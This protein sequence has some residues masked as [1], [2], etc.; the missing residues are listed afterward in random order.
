MAAGTTEVLQ[1][2]SIAHALRIGQDQNESVRLLDHYAATTIA[3]YACIRMCD[4]NGNPSE[5]Y[6][7]LFLL[8]PRK[9]CGL[10]MNVT[11]VE[12]V[13][14]DLMNKMI[15][16]HEEA[17]LQI[18]DDVAVCKWLMKF[19]E[20]W[21]EAYRDQTKQAYD[22]AEPVLAVMH[23]AVL[24]T[25]RVFETHAPAIAT[26]E[27][28]VCFERW[29]DENSEEME[30]CLPVQQ[31]VT[32]FYFRNANLSHYMCLIAGKIWKLQEV[33]DKPGA[34]PSVKQQNLL[35]KQLQDAISNLV[36]ALRKE[37]WQLPLPDELPL[38]CRDHKTRRARPDQQNLNIV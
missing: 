27:V 20:K 31:A 9:Q 35:Q 18:N 13:M 22:I 2:H 30:L 29:Y 34:F 7:K 11:T 5:A 25:E 23:E 10:L 19:K 12:K 32:R 17:L 14:V 33:C 1:V 38:Y 26:S 37:Q 15:E 21:E 36:Q 16:K 8:D 24:K 3:S 28:R 6:W 4:S